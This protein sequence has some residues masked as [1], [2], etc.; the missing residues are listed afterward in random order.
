VLAKGGSQI[1]QVIANH[2]FQTAPAT[3]LWLPEF[4]QVLPR[5]YRSSLKAFMFAISYSLAF[6]KTVSFIAFLF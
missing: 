4:F 5:S 1:G 2:A 3:F 6:A